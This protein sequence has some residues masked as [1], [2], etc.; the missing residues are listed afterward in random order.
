MDARS[1]YAAMSSGMLVFGTGWVNSCADVIDRDLGVEERAGSSGVVNTSGTPPPPP[2]PPLPPPPTPGRR[3]GG[4]I[5]AENDLRQRRRQLRRLT[6]TPP[7][8]PTHAAVHERH[9]AFWWAVGYSPSAS[10]GTRDP[11]RPGP[12]LACPPS[13]LR[14]PVTRSATATTPMLAD[15]NRNVSWRND[16][17]A[18]G[19]MRM[20]LGLPRRFD[21]WGNVPEPAS[22]S[23]MERV[24]E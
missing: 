18:H 17:V 16:G 19:G 11:A 13:R 6:S 9:H 22:P 4:T 3:L 10:S 21:P 8:W 1:S 24:D 20:G 12:S 7:A 15:G 14:S 5:P 2:P 23:G